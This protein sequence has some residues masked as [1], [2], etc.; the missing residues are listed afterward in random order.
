[1][2]ARIFF[3][4]TLLVILPIA[5]AAFAVQ[6][7]VA[8]ITTANLETNL[9]QSLREKARLAEAALAG[10][11]QTE[12][13]SAIEDI[14]ARSQSRVTVIAPTGTVLADS[15]ADPAAMENHAGRPEFAR[16]L[17]GKT[18]VSRRFSTTVGIDFLY[19][20]AP[21]E[22]G[23]A[24]RMALP[25]SEVAAIVTENRSRIA[26]V[27]FCVMLP[28]ILLTALFARRI[29]GQLSNTIAF[30]NELAKGNFDA[31]MFQPARGNLA[32][33]NKL[34]MSLQTTA[35][36]LR[37]MFNQLQDERSRFAAA[38]NGIGEGILVVDR[39]RRIVLF[40]PSIEQMFP[41]ENLTPNAA[42]DEWSNREIS[43]LFERSIESGRATAADLT[44]KEPTERS[45]RVSCAPITN[46]KGKVQAVAAV[47]HDV[48]ELERIDRMRR[49]FV[50]NVSHELRTPL[51]VINGYAETLLDG[52]IDDSDNN[53]RFVKILLQNSQRLSRLTADLMALSQIEGKTREFEFADYAAAEL[54]NQAAEG[55]RP[56]TQ[57]KS[58]QLE[59]APANENVSLECDAGAI[60]QIFANLLDNAV[61]HTPAGGKIT[62]GIRERETK[63]EFY[64]RDTGIGISAEHVPRLFERFYRV[65]KAR[66]RALGGTGLGLAIVK[67]L[68]LAHQ[69]SV[70][71]ESEPGKGATFWFSLPFEPR[72]AAAENIDS[73][74]AALF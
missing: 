68:V 39:K 60:H 55:F 6:F 31:P 17:Q 43:R 63:I 32:E 73:C 3:K 66:S 46:R 64:V 69:G 52:A 35:G 27:T 25:L 47:F 9:E 62:V 21:M 15:E 67:H 14:A 44:V 23:R 10:L 72:F 30:S 49:D 71:V 11:E 1:M 7:L 58:I 70:W 34:G 37:S 19:V 29:S 12:Y 22:G 53:R 13:Q 16:A 74:Q 33:L 45:W 57:Q 36:K 5:V 56:L 18:A 61:K 54:L 40:N 50:I 28:L 20:A 65:D 51:S 8:R 38:V 2:T 59:I 24:V 26:L 48:T 42:L 4:L 41:D